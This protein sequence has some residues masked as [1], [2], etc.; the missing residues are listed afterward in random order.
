MTE[1]LSLRLLSQGCGAV[2]AFIEGLKDPVP[3]MKSVM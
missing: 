3:P 2:K 1:R